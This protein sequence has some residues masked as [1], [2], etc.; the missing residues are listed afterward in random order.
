MV[1][2]E[3][4]SQGLR[5]SSTLGGATLGQ[6]LGTDDR[7]VQRTQLMRYSFRSCIFNLYLLIAIFAPA[8]NR[9]S[10]TTR[11]VP[12]LVPWYATVGTRS[13]DIYGQ[14]YGMNRVW[15]GEGTDTWKYK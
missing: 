10:N 9:V 6:P 12:K 4:P 8:R 5:G 2:P 14:D 15:D 7:T 1:V 13:D 3:T 11:C